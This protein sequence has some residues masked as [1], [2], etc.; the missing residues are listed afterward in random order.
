MT[1]ESEIR[2]KWLIC[3]RLA[4]GYVTSPAMRST[5]TTWLTRSESLTSLESRSR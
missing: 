5:F 1:R 2:L 4:S 3:I